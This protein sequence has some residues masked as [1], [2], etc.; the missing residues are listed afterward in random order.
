MM[1]LMM[2]IRLSVSSG[3]VLF[4]LAALRD[5]VAVVN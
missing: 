1:L 5:S 4:L 2:K 3:K